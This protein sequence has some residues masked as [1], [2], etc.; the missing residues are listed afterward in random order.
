MRRIQFTVLLAVTLTLVWASSAFAAAPYGWTYSYDHWDGDS[1]GYSQSAYHSAKNWSGNCYYRLG[2]S[3]NSAFC[4]AI[5][6]AADTWSEQDINFYFYQLPYL[7]N[8][9]DRALGMNASMP[10]GQIACLY[11]TSV[12]NSTLQRAEVGSWYIR[13]NSNKTWCNGA[14]AGQ[15]D[16]QSK[17]THELGHAIRLMDVNGDWPFGNRPTMYGWWGGNT[18]GE[19]SLATGDITAIT[20]LY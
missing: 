12:W 4:L 6:A 20:N 7:S 1:W 18:I 17:V 14:V 15:Y 3:L 11:G 16:R 2:G 13:F 8:P 10:A 9:Y 19:R 5:E